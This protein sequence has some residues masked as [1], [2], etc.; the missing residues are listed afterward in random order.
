MPW[1]AL[2]NVAPV[3][4]SNFLALHSPSPSECFNYTIFLFC[5]ICQA[6]CHLLSWIL[7]A[8]AWLLSAL[9]SALRL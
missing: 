6:L 7:C 1:K 3:P 4:L 8:L 5:Q 2:L 9:S